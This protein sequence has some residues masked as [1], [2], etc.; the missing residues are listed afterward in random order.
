MQMIHNPFNFHVIS[1]FFNLLKL[2][3]E[4]HW[5]INS[6]ASEKAM[7]RKVMEL[8]LDGHKINTEY[9]EVNLLYDNNS[10]SSNVDE[11][12]DTMITTEVFL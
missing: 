3:Y 9:Q 6:I 8:L 4:L 10:L 12:Y 2:F 11:M 7:L 5:Q 1:V